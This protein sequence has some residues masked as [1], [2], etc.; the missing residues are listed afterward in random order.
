MRMR[1][2]LIITIS[3]ITLWFTGCNGGSDDWTD[4]I[5]LQFSLGTT[6][7]RSGETVN[8]PL[9][10]TTKMVFEFDRPVT[11]AS[12]QKLLSFQ[13]WV[14]NINTGIAAYYTE[15]SLEANGDLV[16]P[17]SSGKT[18]EFRLSHPM[19]VNSC[20]MSMGY[21]GDTFRVTVMNLV[22]E[23]ADGTPA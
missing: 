15:C 23:A 17:T 3:L 6:P 19:S 5:L 22:G 8:V 12:L 4:P 13:I 21:P 20:G 14:E 2:G 16:W 1:I 11:Y 10:Q 7:V 18:I 9:A